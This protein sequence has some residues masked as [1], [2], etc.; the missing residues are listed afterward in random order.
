MLTGKCDGETLSANREARRLA[1]QS[2]TFFDTPYTRDDKRDG[3]ASRAERGIARLSRRAETRLHAPDGNVARPIRAALG[4]QGTSFAKYFEG[5]LRQPTD[6]DCS[7]STATARGGVGGCA[8]QTVLGVDVP[9]LRLQRA[10]ALNTSVT[11][12]ARDFTE[13]RFKTAR[14]VRVEL[15]QKKSIHRLIT[16]TTC[17]HA[18]PLKTRSKGAS[19][20][21]SICSAAQAARWRTPTHP[22]ES[23]STILCAC[24]RRKESLAK[25]RKIRAA[26]LRHS[27]AATLAWENIWVG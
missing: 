12:P 8:T 10:A 27:R 20:A 1:S 13:A 25:R 9:L 5:N 16:R 23:G 6:T 7:R 17:P 22:V 15:I 24:P 11:I 18:R 21:N 2:P 19:F 4:E 26:F 3:V 14:V